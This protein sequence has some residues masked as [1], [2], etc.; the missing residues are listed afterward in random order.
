MNNKGTTLI[1]VMVSV[2]LIAIVM[3]FMFNLLVDLK[4]EES[5]SSKKSNDALNRSAIIHLIQND[6]ISKGIHTI[7]F[8]NDANDTCDEDHL[9]FTID[10]VDRTTKKL[11]VAKKYMVYDNERWSLDSGSYELTKMTY[12]FRHDISSNGVYSPYYFLNISIPVTHDATSR[13][14]YGLDIFEIRS[15]DNVNIPSSITYL[16]KNYTCN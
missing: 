8:C 3:I 5:L 11:I 15:E 12:C 1:E 7:L 10:F 6:I 13:R 2:A 4:N 9:F 14:K 16:N